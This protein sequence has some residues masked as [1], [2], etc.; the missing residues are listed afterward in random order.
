MAH[1]GSPPQSPQR[2][3]VALGLIGLIRLIGLISLM[4]E[5]FG[6]PSLGEG[7]G[8]V[9]NMTHIGLRF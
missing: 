5:P 4:G 6:P 3:E 1:I 2:G 9:S 7:R 8:W